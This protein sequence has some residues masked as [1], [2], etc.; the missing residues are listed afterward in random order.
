MF[1][2]FCIAIIT[3]S[4]SIKDY[5]ENRYNNIIIN[6]FL[7]DGR[8]MTKIDDPIP[9]TPYY[10]AAAICAKTLYVK[11]KVLCLKVA[12]AYESCRSAHLQATAATQIDTSTDT[13]KVVRKLKRTHTF[14]IAQRNWNTFLKGQTA[15]A[16]DSK[17][18]EFALLEKFTDQQVHRFRLSIEGIDRYQ[19]WRPYVENAMTLKNGTPMSASFIDL[20]PGK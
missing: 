3:I 17:D 18:K 7:I 5:T 11:A 15:V 16:T 14:E 2:I 1:R 13:H 4:T 9:Y 8:S 19:E 20:A 12:A 10:Y 6:K